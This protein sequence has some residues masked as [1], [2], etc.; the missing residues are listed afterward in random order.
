M[1]TIKTIAVALATALVA[2]LGFGAI[3]G[4]NL[5]GAPGI[6]ILPS[7]QQP[8][9]GAVYSTSTATNSTLLTEA[10]DYENT[11][12]MTLTQ[13][14]GTLTLMASTSVPGIPNPGDT[15]TIFVRNATTTA[16]IDLTIAAGTGTLLKRAASST[17][18]VIG[19]T[20]GANFFRLD[21]LR[22]SN[23]DIEVLLTKFED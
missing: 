17:V 9:S 11:V 22:K 4:D 13:N 15:R 19:D 23:T 21:L 18:T 1:D 2:V 7:A 14:D 16:G 20:D 12:E 8:Y 3:Q 5:A 10:I 6:N